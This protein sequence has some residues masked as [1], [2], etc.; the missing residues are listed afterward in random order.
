VLFF[1]HD[2]VTEFHRADESVAHAD[3]IREL[4]TK[5]Y[6][7]FAPS[8]LNIPSFDDDYYTNKFWSIVGKGIWD[9]K[10][11]LSP[12]FAILAILV[13]FLFE[14]GFWNF[15]SAKLDLIGEVIKHFHVF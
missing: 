8:F 15:L 14:H 1:E 11:K 6:A 2:D 13:W 12:L 3:Y 10:L 9:N 4:D 7:D 5:S